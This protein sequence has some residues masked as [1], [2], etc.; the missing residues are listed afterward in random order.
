MKSIFKKAIQSILVSVFLVTLF[1]IGLSYVPYN[2]YT[3]KLTK[4]D[5]EI[6]FQEMVHFGDSHYYNI[7]NMDIHYF[8]SSGYVYM[9][10]MIQ[11]END[12]DKKEMIDFIGLE[13]EV[14]SNLAKITN[15]DSQH[16]HMFL[17]DKESVNADIT[18]KELV[19]NFKAEKLE[20]NDVIKGSSITLNTA[21][22][23]LNFNNDI[24]ISISRNLMKLGLFINEKFDI[25]PEGFSKVIISNRNDKLIEYID[26]SENKKIYVQYGKLHWKDFESKMLEK[27]YTVEKID[28]KIVF[29]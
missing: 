3:Y 17:V 16:N 25:T 12:N 18:A 24:S 9:Y 23:K 7:V 4:G 13:P 28:T 5:T 26:N 10:E 15:L 1:F 11:V 8:K 21:L 27:G 20:K 2:A 29:K 22:T 14:F 19:E 6:I